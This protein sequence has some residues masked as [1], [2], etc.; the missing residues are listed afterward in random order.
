MKRNEVL[1]SA[2]V[3]MILENV[4]VS[5]RSQMQRTVYHMVLLI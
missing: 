1:A 3:R 5:A 2:A 4:T